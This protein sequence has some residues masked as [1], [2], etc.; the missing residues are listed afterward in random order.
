MW[1]TFPDEIAGFPKLIALRD[2]VGNLPEIY[3]Y[4]HSERAVREL[5][6]VKYFNRFKEE[7]YNRSSGHS[8]SES[9]EMDLE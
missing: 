8:S 6:P 3:S 1:V 7:K 5:S 4:E 9:K 2:R